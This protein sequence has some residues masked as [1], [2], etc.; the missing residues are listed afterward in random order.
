MGERKDYDLIPEI[1]NYFQ[2]RKQAQ[3]ESFFSGKSTADSFLDGT[4]GRND[5]RD[6]LECTPEQSN[7]LSK[8]LLYAP[9]YQQDEEPRAGSF[10]VVRS[11]FARSSQTGAQP[12][13]NA[14][15]GYNGRICPRL[16]LRY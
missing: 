13:L 1:P 5:C 8:L 15:N 7:N 16:I 3:N 6:D 12:P 9:R 10:A 11:S 2:H 14:N 4:R